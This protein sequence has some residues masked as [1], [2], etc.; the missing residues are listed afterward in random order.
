[1]TNVDPSRHTLL[2]CFTLVARH[3]H[4][5]TNLGGLLHKY[6]VQNEEIPVSLFLRIAKDHGFKAQHIRLTWERLFKMG[7]AF[8]G[9]AVLKNGKSV[10]LSG[11]VTQDN[12]QKVA[13]LD[14]L[15]LQAG[16]KL[17]TREEAEEIWNGSAVLIKRT[18][19]LLDQNQPFSLR[20]FI[21]EIIREKKLF[22]DIAISAMVMNILALGMPIFFQLV[23]DKVL[24]HHGISTLQALSI[25]IIALILFEGGFGY[26]KRLLLLHATNKI[27]MR[28]ARRTFGHL[29]HLPID[30]FDHTSSGVLLKHMQQTEK[31]RGFLTGKLFM[32]ILDLTI[33]VVLFPVIFMYSTALSL[34]VLAFTIVIGG[35]L[36]LVIPT[37]R[38]RLKA[39]YE[40]EGDRQ[41]TLV[42]SIHGMHTIKA[43][44]LEPLQSKQWDDKSA[45][46]IQMQFN[47]GKLSMSIQSITEF[48]QKLMGIV[49]LWA[50]ISYVFEQTL[51]VGA[52]IAFNMLSQRVSGPLVGLVSLI[53]QYQEVGLSI[54]M[55]GSVMNRPTE[56]PPALRGLTPQLQGRIDVE[57]LVFRYPSSSRPA[58]QGVNLSIPAGSVVGIV[59]RSG[60]G[61]STLS[62]LIQ[63]LYIVQEGAVKIDGIDIREIDLPHLRRSIGTVLQENFLFRGTVRQNISFTKPS[64]T[65]EEIVMVARLAGA[66]EFV[67]RLPQGYDTMLTEN[68]S[69][70]SGGQRQRL[71]I[72]RA[73]L[74]NPRIMILDEATSALDAESEAIIQENLASIAKGRTM[75]I[76]SHRLSMLANSDVILVIDAGK[77]VGAAP[78]NELL[79]TCPIYH[80]L[81]T[82]QN[83]HVTAGGGQA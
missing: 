68:A 41:S 22:R 10:V 81:W 74:L 48:L 19:S 60:S 65:F 80:E 58:L 44:A 59:G 64:A 67:Q 77:V 71:A 61:K 37:F 25:G 2:L 36:L 30:F 28:L 14:P 29:L 50:G 46:S 9:V 1:M 72:A 73:L 32:T 20:W 11:V 56:R 3:F 13:L 40:A 27:D 83:R 8:P 76:I 6:A 66:D 15:N 12:V 45:R 34:I 42:E 47:V 18:F 49:V 16:F 79:Q 7:Q 78:H 51:S 35:F 4:V 38:V 55:L 26:I 33:L 52:L 43:L 57:H 70:L 5:D 24:V 31:I 17:L 62:R 63:G 69:N 21:P 53:H 39:L 23:L 75:L 54:D 82:V